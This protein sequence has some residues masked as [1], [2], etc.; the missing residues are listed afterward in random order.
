M[1]IVTLT[2]EELRLA[3]THGLER[4]MSGY[5]AKRAEMG[6]KGDRIL[7]DIRGSICEMAVAKFLGRYWS[8]CAGIGAPDVSGFEVRSTTHST[9]HLLISRRDDPELRAVLC[10]WDGSRIDQVRIAGWISIAEAQAD[11]SL[12]GTLPGA[13][14]SRACFRVP[15]GRLSPLIGAPGRSSSA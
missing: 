12:W 13:P 5:L 14:Q 2:H 8:G 11:A 6:F 3:G 10:L 1:N 15:Q 7:S 9:G 4:A